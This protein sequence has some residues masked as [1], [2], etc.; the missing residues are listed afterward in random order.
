MSRHVAFVL[1]GLGAGGAERVVAVLTGTLIA[2]GWQA[3]VIAFDAPNAAV[4]H[5]FAPGVRLIRLNVPAGGIWQQLRRTLALR[6]AIAGGGFDVVVSFL[7]KINVLTL[8][9]SQGLKV[10]VV[11]SERN[12][13][14]RQPASRVWRMML[15]LL[16]PQANAIVMQTE[17]SK[18]CLPASQRARAHVIANPV[19]CPSARPSPSDEKRITAVGRLEAQK[20]FDLLIAAFARIV[21]DNA[22][23][24]LVIWGDGPLRDVLTG[25]AARL[26]LGDRVCLAGNSP[27]PG[28]WIDPAGIF[29][30]PSRYEGFPNVLAEAMAGGMAVI[31]FD[32]DF[33]PRELIASDI[34]G[35]LAPAEDVSALA[36]GMALLMHDSE[37]RAILASH[38]ARA[39][40]RFQAE[41]VGQKWLHL[42][43]GL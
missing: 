6:R 25:Q 11:V 32:C 28:G 41:K 16:Y 21:A 10:P 31:A 17:R 37:Y 14:W 38:A 1:A 22:D 19:A 2:Q 39:S 4:Y 27:V 40:R 26:G 9:A 15:S 13:P 36:D 24:R 29:V 3:T 12:N 42:L 43:G 7:T 18:A 34:E 35:I 8:L 23:W 5:T 30:L 20:G 33:G